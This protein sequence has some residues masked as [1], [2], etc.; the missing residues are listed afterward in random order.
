MSDTEPQKHCAI[1]ENVYITEGTRIFIHL[2]SAVG[3]KNP[4]TKKNMNKNKTDAISLRGKGTAAQDQGL[5]FVPGCK[6]PTAHMG[7]H[8]ELKEQ[9]EWLFYKENIFITH[10]QWVESAVCPMLAF[11]LFRTQIR[12]DIIG[13]QAWNNGLDEQG[14]LMRG[15]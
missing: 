6:P 7:I 12:I 4:I 3:Q 13:Y 2:K 10:R 11:A 8:P 15:Y 14:L 9:N 1:K 5:G